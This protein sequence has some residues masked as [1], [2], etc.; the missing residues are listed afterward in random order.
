MQLK[1]MNDNYRSELEKL[2]ELLNQRKLDFDEI[3]RQV[4]FFLSMEFI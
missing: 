1:Q 4:N 3:S 2:Y